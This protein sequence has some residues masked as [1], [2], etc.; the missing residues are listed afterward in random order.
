[1]NSI[2]MSKGARTIVEVCAGVRP[3]EIVLIVTEHKMIKIAESVASAVYANGAEPILSVMV[4]RLFDGKEPPNSIAAA[5]KSSDVFICA[6]YK[7]I[8]HTQAV[9]NAILSGSRGIMLTQFDENMLIKGGIEADFRKIAPMC[10]RMSK[11]L[12]DKNEIVL[13]TPHGTNLRFS[14]K[15]RKGNALTCLVSKGEFAPVPT[16]EANV[17]PLEGTANGTIVA[18]A[19]IPYINIGV[20]QEPVSAEVINGMIVSISGGEQAKMLEKNLQSMNDPLVYNIAELG[21]GLNPK[22]TFIGSMLEDEGVYGSVHI[23]I[24]TNIT[25]GGKTKASCHYDLIMT[26]PTV[27]ADGKALLKN[28]EICI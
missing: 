16:I 10:H 9:K 15:G 1:M 21:I 4:P 26:E 17:S 8:T 3:K 7:S 22:C 27:I 25:L 19:S 11:E 14:S 12:E 18:N 23:G 6:V 20:L 28:G 24:G 13:T 5:M 2:L